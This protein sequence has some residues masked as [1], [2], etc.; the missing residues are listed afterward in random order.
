MSVN[1]YSTIFNWLA[2]P[3]SIVES[4]IKKFKLLGMTENLPTVEEDPDCHWE[5]HENCRKVNINPRIVRYGQKF[6]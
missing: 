2:I 3:R 1:S 5:L 6:W 4:I